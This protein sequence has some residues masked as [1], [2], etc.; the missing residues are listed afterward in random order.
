M[1][2]SGPETTVG[3]EVPALHLLLATGWCVTALHPGTSQ[4]TCDMPWDCICCFTRG[5][6]KSTTTPWHFERWAFGSGF[7]GN[8]KPSPVNRHG[9]GASVALQNTCQELFVSWSLMARSTTSNI[10][11][12]HL[13]AILTLFGMFLHLGAC[14]SFLA[15]R[16]IIVA[17]SLTSLSMMASSA[18]SSV[19]RAAGRRFLRALDGG[20]ET[21]RHLVARPA[22]HRARWFTRPRGPGA[23]QP[24]L[25]RRHCCLKTFG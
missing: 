10:Q 15:S 19:V 24:R 14:R 18:A 3:A 1:T 8:L 25:L 2:P 12:L 20:D 7:G 11:G 23:F 13:A 16:M 22:R 6:S 9:A 21:Q 17:L 4:G 5:A